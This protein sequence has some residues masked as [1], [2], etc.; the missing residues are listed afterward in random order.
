MTEGF[1][2]FTALWL[3]IL[4]SISPC[5]LASNI[6]A[7]S[8]VGKRVGRPFYVLMSGLFYTLGRTTFYTLLGFS[9]SFAMQSIPVVSDFLQTKMNYIIA[10]L[11]ILIG[12]VLLDVIPLNIP[13]ISFKGFTEKKLAHFGLW[14]AFLIGAL[15]ASALCPVSAALFFSSLI[16]SKGSIPALFVYGIGTGLPVLVSSFV[17]AFFA[18]KISLFYK[19]TARLEKCARYVTAFVFI[20]VGVY[21]LWR[22]F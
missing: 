7:V 12:I 10:P 18:N 16:N 5:S 13:K 2:I 21:S 6:A 11:M 9:L 4:T 17:L 20:G 8:F 22:I 3:G 14:G 19:E 15:F 1:T